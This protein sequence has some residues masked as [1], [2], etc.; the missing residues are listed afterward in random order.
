[1]D[2]RLFFRNFDALNL[3]EFLDPRLHLLGLRSLIPKPT[4]EGPR[5][6]TRSF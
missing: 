3:F 2:D 1:M 4:N 5:C 6:S